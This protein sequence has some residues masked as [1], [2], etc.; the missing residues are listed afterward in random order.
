MRTVMQVKRLTVWLLL[1]ACGAIAVQTVPSDKGSH[2]TTNSSVDVT[3]SGYDWSQASASWPSL[4]A[5]TLATITLMPCPTGLVDDD[6]DQYVYISE[7]PRDE[8]VMIASWMHTGTC[9][10]G[11]P[12]GMISFYPSRNHSAG[13]YTLK[14]AS[15]GLQEALNASRY[16]YQR[17]SRGGAIRLPS[18]T[19]LDVY[20][21]VSVRSWNVTLDLNGSQIKFHQSDTGLCVGDCAQ[22]WK[23][24]SYFS[25][26]V[27]MQVPTGKKKGTFVSLSSGKTGDSQPAW[28]SEVG[29]TTT[30][31]GVTWMRTGSILN[32]TL[33]VN[34]T[35]I[36]ARVQPAVD[37][38]RWAAISVNANKTRILNLSSQYGYAPKGDVY[39]FGALVE[40]DDDQAFLLDGLDTSTG[41]G[42]IR[43]DSEFC[44]SYITAPGPFNVG[45]A[46]GWLKNMNLSAQCDGNGV[47][48]QSGNTLHISDSVIQ[49][50]NQFGVRYSM[51]SGGYGGLM[52]DGVYME[53]GSGCSNPLYVSV[54]P[55]ASPDTSS[56]A[57][58][59][60]QGRS[61]FTNPTL[62]YR[63][64]EG[65]AGSVPMF[66][67]SG[68]GGTTIY[69]YYVVAYND[70]DNS[71]S[72]PI[73]FGQARPTGASK[74]KIAWPDMPD[75]RSFDILRVGGP[76]GA[77]TVAPYGSGPYAVATGLIRS[78]VCSNGL[79][80]SEDTQEKPVNYTV[81]ASAL[82]KVWVPFANLWPGAL[83]LEP[84]ANG[85]MFATD[86]PT[87]YTDLLPYTSIVSFS[88]GTFPQI[89]A[90]HCGNPGAGQSSPSWPTCLNSYYSQSSL[91]YMGGIQSGGNPFSQF[92][93]GKLNVGYNSAIS[94]PLHLIT[95]FDSNPD[96]SSAYG[97]ARAH[98]C[99]VP[100][101][102]SNTIA[103][104]YK[105]I[106]SATTSYSANDWVNH[107]DSYYFNVGRPTDR[108]AP[109]AAPWMLMACDTKDVFIGVDSGGSNVEVGLS[110][111]SS[112]SISRYIDNIGDGKAWLERLT[113]TLDAFRVPVQMD[114]TLKIGEAGSSLNQ[115]AIFSTPS[116]LPL[117]VE[118]HS[119]SDQTFTVRGLTISD[120]VG[121]VTPPSVLGDLSLI[122]YPQSAGRILLHFCNLSASR[123]TPPSGIYRFSAI[124]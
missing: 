107:N 38:G 64:G 97:A 95:L 6:V 87:Y 59:I 7:P 28:D 93:K 42:T 21:K 109:P 105:G 116:V 124:H 76:G 52:M 74:F 85:P 121:Q 65:P 43:C 48:W 23:P 118:P 68:T 30:D 70:H 53:Y 1:S 45:S 41:L 46:V 108:S 61:N 9:S 57:G 82:G 49:G 5:G 112:K 25:A 84:T 77:F 4:K 92:V 19:Q 39:T 62:S 100:G 60:V 110:F 11:H 47:D 27:R 3:P 98:L 104:R 12:S 33:T 63:G 35:I 90:L 106:W 113:S 102:E 22:Q 26:N 8:V 79:C 24:D 115:V 56:A 69:N 119:C 89:Y 122:G 13:T 101:Y 50:Y 94:G 99:T 111:G 18:G 54:F 14:S 91:R 86:Q 15:G 88:G 123:L 36:G 31:A 67:G 120:V 103:Q 17:V 80:V 66:T 51:K 55:P 83:V 37:K 72:M 34:A 73:L 16:M 71:Y 96:K 29:H 114:S 75:A 81:Q 32:S 10:L 44:G 2:P 20:A 117:A 58:I 40:V 78:R